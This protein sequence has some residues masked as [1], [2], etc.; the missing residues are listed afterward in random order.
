[1]TTTKSSAP[2]NATKDDELAA[3]KEAALD[4]YE[5]LLE[6]KQHLKSAAE[7]AGVDMKDEAVEQLL[8]GRAKAEELGDQASVFVR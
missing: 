2:K 3:S 7:A 8:K 6:A 4:A 5:K 1:M